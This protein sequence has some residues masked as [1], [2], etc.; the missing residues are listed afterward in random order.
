M[1]HSGDL[2]TSTAQQILL[3]RADYGVTVMANT[4]LAYGDAQAIADRI[5]ALLENKTVPPAAAWAY[6]LLDAV[7]LA[8]IAGALLLAAHGVR[9]SRRRGARRVR[10]SI[11]IS[12]LCAAGTAGAVGHNPPAS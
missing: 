10:R 9:L 11:A 5:V 3:T 6:M 1:W 8:L 4:G 12:V 2:F 7:F